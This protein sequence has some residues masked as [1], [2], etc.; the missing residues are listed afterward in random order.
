MKHLSLCTIVI[1]LL[2]AC[3][4]P[5]SESAIQTAIALTQVAE[6]Y[7]RSR[8]SSDRHSGAQAHGIAHCHSH[9]DSHAHANPNTEADRHGY[10][11]RTGIWNN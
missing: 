6:G 10:P 1:A 7:T 5:P 8:D 4:S 11:G 2:A 9:P 3:S